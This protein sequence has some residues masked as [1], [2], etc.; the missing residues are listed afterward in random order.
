[1]ASKLK[2][3]W[4]HIDLTPVGVECGCVE[5]EF[6]RWDGDRCRYPEVGCWT[7]AEDSDGNPV[8]LTDAQVEAAVWAAL[9]DPRHG[10]DLA[11]R[12]ERTLDAERHGDDGWE[13]EPLT[14]GELQG[15]FGGPRY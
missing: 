4:E 2:R 11:E 5:V 15:R 1:M 8:E 3:G 12:I 10:R 7:K 6:D 14:I 9:D 13:S